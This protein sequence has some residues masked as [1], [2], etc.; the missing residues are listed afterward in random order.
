MI[1]EIERFHSRGRHTCKF[2]ETKES[3]Y[4]RKEFNSHRT[5]LVPNMATV[6]SCENGAK[7]RENAAAS[8]FSHFSGQS[9]TR[10]K[11]S[12]E[13]SGHFFFISAGLHFGDLGEILI[14]F[15][16][17]KGKSLNF[18]QLFSMLRE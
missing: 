4:I 5:G 15:R 7:Q 1:E 12:E 3:V 6:T 9:E 16:T 8:G 10:L 13:E 17:R 2:T 18:F 14:V 11:V